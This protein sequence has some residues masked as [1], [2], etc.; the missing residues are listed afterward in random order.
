MRRSRPSILANPVLIGATATLVLIVAV[1]LS[2]TANNGLPFIPTRQLKVNLPN[3]NELVKGNEVREGGY[4]VGVVSSMSP[5][6]LGDGT[7]VAQ[8]TLKLNKNAGGFPVDSTAIVRPRTALGLEYL[9]LQKGSSTHIIPD[10]GTLPA[11]QVQ[12]EPELDQVFNMFDQRTRVAARTDLNEFGN[13]F[14]GRG[15]D[16]N[17]TIQELPRTFGYLAP[18]AANLASPETNL[19]NF[20]RQLD[21]TAATIAPVSQI[22]AHSFTTMAN[23]FAAIDRDPQAL[24]DTIA[25]GPATLT[26]A[27]NSLRAQMPFLTDSA[28]FGTDLSAAARALHGALPTLNSALEVGTR[29]TRRTPV[30]YRNLQEAMTALRNLAQSPTT[31]AALRGLTATVATLQPQLRFLGPY[32]T[33]CNYWSTFWEFAAESQASPGTGGTALR[34]LLNTADPAQTNTLNSTGANLPVN[35]TTSSDGSPPEALHNQPYGAAVTDSGKADCEYGQRGYI[36]RSPH[37]PAGYNIATDPH[38]EVGYRAGPTYRHYNNGG[39]IA[40]AGLG[41]DQVPAGE[42]FTRQPG[43]LG[44]NLDPNLLDSPTAD[45]PK[46]SS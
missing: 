27:T 18:V 33:V 16:L 30:L 5:V 37:A 8:A 20:F 46:P 15:P 11:A 29:V 28:A 40:S 38:N 21:I 25:K 35:N 14:A 34:A 43:G 36:K 12:Q 19:Q 39:P 23:T 17:A 26:V 6:R 13:A 32:V 31:D 7:V 45:P 22:F 24:R 42:T 41:P 1:Y 10:G 9:Q 4:R 3:G 44:A 2:Y